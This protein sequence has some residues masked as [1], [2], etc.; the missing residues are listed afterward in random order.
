MLSATRPM[1]ESF[2]K[3]W[4]PRSSSTCHWLMRL[5]HHAPRPRCITT[6]PTAC[7]PIVQ[8]EQQRHQSCPSP[9]RS[10]AEKNP[11]AGGNAG[12]KPR[13]C[14]LRRKEPAPQVTSSA[15][16]SWLPAG[17]AV[18]VSLCIPHC[19]TR[20]SCLKFHR[21]V[22]AY[23]LAGLPGL[24]ASYLVR[25]LIWHGNKGMNDT[26]PS[27]SSCLSKLHHAVTYQVG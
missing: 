5:C 17:Q 6:C 22:Q 24:L 3:W 1:S 16:G 25:L 19:L 9:K 21:H 12:W 2:C 11:V 8:P 7:K 10:A 4:R 18:T 27:F 14:T 26:I 23:V 15:C 20:E 13:A